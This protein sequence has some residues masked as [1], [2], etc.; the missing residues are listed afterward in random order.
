MSSDP[1]R[2]VRASI[3]SS[4]GTRDH[5]A[6][7]RSRT[8]GASA[9]PSSSG[10]GV[11]SPSRRPSVVRATSSSRSTRL[12]GVVDRILTDQ[13]EVGGVRAVER[14]RRPRDLDRTDEA[15]DLLEHEHVEADHPVDL[16]ATTL[17]VQLSDDRRGRRKVRRHGDVRPRSGAGGAVRSGGETE[18]PISSQP[19]VGCIDEPAIGSTGSGEVVV[20]AEPG[21]GDPAVVERVARRSFP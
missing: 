18:R 12:T 19:V 5:A 15:D 6:T 13:E 21:K 14:N 11:D 16:P 17:G 1:S 2:P 10:S 8:I 4:A 9:L 7:R 20:A 3:A